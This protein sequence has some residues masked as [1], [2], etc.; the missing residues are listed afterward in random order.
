MRGYW[1]ET[2]TRIEN[3]GWRIADVRSDGGPRTKANAHTH[4]AMPDRGDTSYYRHMKRLMSLAVLSALMLT[5]GEPHRP[6]ILGVAHIAIFAKDIEQSRAFYRDFLG[7]Q[8][9]YVLKNPNGSLS[10]TFFK[11]NDRQ[12]IE[13]SPEK[14]PN[15]DRLNHISIETDDAEA[16]RAYL[17]SKGVRV[18][19]KVSKGRIGNSNFTVKDPEGHTVEIVQYEPDGWTVR[20]KDKFMPDTLISSR[21]MHVGIIVTN[22]EPEMKFYAGT[23]GFREFWRGSKSGKTLSWINL[24]VP[25]GD[26]YVEFMLYKEQPSASD[27]G[28]AHHL[29]L[30]VPSAN[31]AVAAL[32]ARPYRKQYS[33]PIEIRVGVNRKRQ[34]NLF[35][36][37]GTRTELMEPVTIDGKPTPSS[38]APVR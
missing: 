11:I 8:E 22:L 32:N 35:D 36:P 4:A 12:Y 5:A 10:M 37:D 25:D 17:G 15:S 31:A 1:Y 26:D 6:K 9:P 14:E 18:P 29:A 28:S 33:R 38:T 16:M 21:L 20:E 27:R 3:Y 24:K 30:E 23:L 19:E 7:F 34:V 13:L 2:A